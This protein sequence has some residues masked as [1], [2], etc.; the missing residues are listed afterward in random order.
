MP[1]NL[2]GGGASTGGSG[3][4]TGAGTGEGGGGK[5]AAAIGESFV[6]SVAGVAGAP[7]PAGT[8]TGA[9]GFSLN[10]AAASSAGAA[11]GG[12]VTGG[13]TGDFATGG[14]IPIGGSGSGAGSTGDA[15]TTVE[16]AGGGGMEV[17][18]AGAAG[19][20]VCGL[21]A[22]RG[23]N[24]TRSSV[25]AIPSGFPPETAGG[26]AGT[27][28]RDAVAGGAW[29]PLSAP[30]PPPVVSAAGA[31]G[32]AAGPVGAG[33]LPTRRRGFKRRAGGWDSSLIP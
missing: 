32:A 2:A 26:V 22:R 23:F 9:L 11:I 10:L 31:T 8:G 14:V 33:S 15:A 12:G 6:A 17:A 4:S 30:V 5:V 1:E 7:I 18:S 19:W 20:A 21:T 29:L 16:G 3:A 13:S 25:E 24:R 27:A 28:G